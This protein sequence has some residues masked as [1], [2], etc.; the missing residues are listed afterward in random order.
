VFIFPT[1]LFIINL[2]LFI[3]FLCFFDIEYIVIFIKYF[4]IIFFIT[5]IITTS[6]SIFKKHEIN[7]GLSLGIVF[8][9]LIGVFVLQY[10][11]PELIKITNST[12]LINILK[13]SDK[14]EVIDYFIEHKQKFI[15]CDIFIY[16]KSSYCS[17]IEWE[18]I[19]TI[20]VE[21][22]EKEKNSIMNCDNIYIEFKEK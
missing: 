19:D 4:I 11:L 7:K 16:N 3:I 5:L 21:L 18:S 22:I 12:F 15:L 10:K 2:L 14:N 20:K 9:S 6:I 13:D 17:K 1:L 8:I